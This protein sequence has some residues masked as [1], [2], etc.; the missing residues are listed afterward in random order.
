MCQYVEIVMKIVI[1]N[2]IEKQNNIEKNSI[3]IKRI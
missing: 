2:N 3:K 1:L